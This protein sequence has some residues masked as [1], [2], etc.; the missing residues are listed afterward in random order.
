MHIC[1]RYAFILR[2]RACSRIILSF[3]PQFYL[4][5]FCS[6]FFLHCEWRWKKN[7]INIYCGQ[8]LTDFGQLLMAQSTM[9]LLMVEIIHPFI[10]AVL[11]LEQKCIWHP[12]HLLRAPRP[13]LLSLRIISIIPC[14]AHTYDDN[15]QHRRRPTYHPS[16]DVRK[17]NWH[18]HDYSVAPHKIILIHQTCCGCVSPVCTLCVCV[19]DDLDHSPLQYIILCVAKQKLSESRLNEI[20]NYPF[21][22]RACCCCDWLHKHNTKPVYVGQSLCSSFVGWLLVCIF[23]ALRSWFNASQAGWRKNVWDVR[24]TSGEYGRGS[25]G[26]CKSSTAIFPATSIHH[27]SR[28]TS[29]ARADII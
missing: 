22:A 10:N 20:P 16:D 23:N 5:F 26:I 11:E 17:S 6:F 19:T 9:Q 1:T 28:Q 13:F 15:K 27:K 8:G 25:R 3:D 4:Y 7:E 21:A 12:D 18:F 24:L 2:I 14:A 29:A